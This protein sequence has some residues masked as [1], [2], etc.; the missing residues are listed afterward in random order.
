MLVLTVF[1]APRCNGVVNG[2]LADAHAI[3][4]TRGCRLRF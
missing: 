1:A 4:L 2:S 3:A